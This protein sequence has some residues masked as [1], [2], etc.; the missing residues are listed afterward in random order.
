MGMGSCGCAGL[1]QVVTRPIGGVAGAAHAFLEDG[2]VIVVHIRVGIEQGILPGVDLGL[3]DSSWQNRLLVAVTEQ[4][5]R[6]E[7][8]HLVELLASIGN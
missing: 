2:E 1:R 5:T 3:F 6:A 4:R 8:D 7:M